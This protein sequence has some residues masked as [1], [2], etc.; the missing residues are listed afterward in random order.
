MSF[1]N[2]VHIAVTELNETLA[3]KG[4]VVISSCTEECFTLA[5][6]YEVCNL[7][8]WQWCLL[9]SRATFLDLGVLFFGNGS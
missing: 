4:I 8:I 5:C 2:G 3:T 6:S 7:W 1:Q 9:I